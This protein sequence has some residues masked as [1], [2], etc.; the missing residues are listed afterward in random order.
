MPACDLLANPPHT[1]A[2]TLGF[3]CHM[4]NL[5]ESSARASG[6]CRSFPQMQALTPRYVNPPQSSSHALHTVQL[7]PAHM[8]TITCTHCNTNSLQI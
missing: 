5:D 6:A 7:V 4:Q 3:T 8:H 2:R 1:A